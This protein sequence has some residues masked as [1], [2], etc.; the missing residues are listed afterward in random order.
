[1]NLERLGRLR[2]FASEGSCDQTGEPMLE[3]IQSLPLWAVKT[4]AMTLGVLLAVGFGLLFFRWLR[5]LSAKLPPR[6]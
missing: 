2:L 1:M 5:N 3:Y 6:E 4:L